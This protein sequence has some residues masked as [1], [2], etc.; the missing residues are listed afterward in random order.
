MISTVLIAGGRAGRS[1]RVVLAAA[2]LAG[3]AV[4]AGCRLLPASGSALRPLTREMLDNRE[5]NFDGSYARG[6]VWLEDGRHYLHR[7]GGRLLRIDAL[8]EETEPAYDQDAL[9]AALG[10]HEDF[11]EGQAERFARRPMAWTDNRRAVLIRHDNR[12][13]LYRFAE[14]ELTRLTDEAGPRRVV[15]LSPQGDA[16]SFVRDNNLF[17]ID[18]H[19]TEQRQLTHDGSDNVLNGILDWVYQEEIYGRGRWQA[20]WWRD[21]AKYLAYLRLDQ[22]RVPVYSIVDYMPHMSE[23]ERTHYPKAGDPLPTVRLVIAEPAAREAVRVDLSK[24][25]GVDI[26]IVRVSWAPDG[27]LIFSVQDREQRW[28][29]LNEAEPDSGEMRTLI[30]ETSPAWTNNIRHPH[31]LD[32]GSFL[33]LSERDGYRHIYH[34]TRDGELIRPVTAGEWPVRGL[35]GYDGESGWVYFTGSRETVLETHACRVRLDGGV[36]ER[37]TEPGY[38]HRVSFDPTLHLFFDTFSNVATPTSVHL[39][40]AGGSLVRVVSENR[41][42]ALDEYVWSAPELLQVPNRDGLPMNV[43]LIRP[44]D[45]DPSKKYPV[46]CPVYGGPDAPTVRNRGSG[47]GQLFYQYLAQQGYVIWRCDP[48]SSTGG[49][50]GAAWHAY[51]SLGQ[52]ELDDLEDSLYWLID[53]GYV[54]PERIGITGYSYGGYLAAYA[55]THSEMFKVGIA[56]ALLS[57]WRNYDAV[58]VERYMQTPDN[59]HDGYERACVWNAAENLHGRLL[60]VHGLQDDNVHF[61][62]AAELIDALQKHE[63]MFDLMV[64]PRDRHGIG[65]GRRH[66]RELRLRYIRENL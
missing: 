14:D 62:N 54:D 36:I 8:T 58:Y 17:T 59:N 56:G 10:A 48:Y 65:H 61:Q 57:D 60:I 42:E 21:D 55:M 32:D 44:P 35:L 7:R 43:Q 41:V 20:N 31:W 5:V 34:Y 37:L 46:L 66:H 18:T 25:E 22:S 19:T 28:L 2:C 12:F 27:K 24:Y 23:V 50:A 38:T 40:N 11:S 29:E 4:M 49:V 53:Q 30:R 47:R 51:R 39:R 16:V 3:L 1:A 6:M 9:K 13:Y 63:Q 64:Y 15:Q 45:F 52:N 26:L 33:W